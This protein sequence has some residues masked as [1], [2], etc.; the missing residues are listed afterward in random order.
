MRIQQ[1]TLKDAEAHTFGNFNVLV[2]GNAVGKTTLLTELYWN[3]VRGHAGRYWVKEAKF[4]ASNLKADLELLQSSL[5][6]HYEGTSHYFYSPAARDISGNPDRS[7]D[8][9]FGETE[10]KSLLTLPAEQVF[11]TWKHRAPFVAFANAD[12][13]LGLADSVGKM[14]L[15]E[16][17]GDP[18]N[19]LFRYKDQLEKIHTKILE[20]FGFHLVILDH[21]GTSLELGIAT[22][23]APEFDHSASNLQAEFEKIEEWKRTRFTPLS[24]A[25]HGIRSMVRLLAM[26]FDPVSKVLMIDEPEM[27]L[28]PKQRRWLG[29][30]LV[31][32]A[33]DVDVQVFLVTHDPVILQGILDS[34]S[35]TKIFRV[36]RTAGG[37]ST[38]KTCDLQMNQGISTAGNQEQYLQSMFYQR[39]IA[40]EGPSDR[41]FY[42]AFEREFPGIEDKDLGFIACSGKGS[43]K[44]FAFL[45]SKVGLTCAYIYD[46]DA[47]LF[48]PDVVRDVFAVCGGVGDPLQDLESAMRE[49]DPATAS[50]KHD[51]RKKAIEKVTGY[52]HKKGV[53]SE[54]ARLNRALFDKIQVTLGAHRI[55]LVPNGE[56]ESWAP[57][58]EGKARFAELAPEF[59]RND[60]QLLSGIKQFL[61][62]VFLSVGALS[63]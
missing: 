7:G 20:R 49:A 63:G 58:L 1:L 28:Y 48:N 31:E 24:Q 23:K 57:D 62:R 55:F 50:T 21:V 41:S 25:G 11:G 33:K 13:R 44:S 2:G 3:S 5:H 29:Q 26:L 43:T 16:S 8:L 47:I 51:E 40:V 59:I 53:T 27:H 61:S 12:S 56:L 9:R 14:S 4:E 35:T 22:E 38:V 36:D 37:A 45:A 6:K 18:I 60:A 32:L 54:W 39:C 34:A 19:V 42:Q 46:F 15:R 17:P 10:I 30:Q 52:H